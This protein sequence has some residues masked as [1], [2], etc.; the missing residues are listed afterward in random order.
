MP[1]VHCIHVWNGA[2][3][4]ILAYW[5]TFVMVRWTDTDMV[6]SVLQ[7]SIREI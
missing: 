1:T 4:I 5:G 6:E 7:D 3:G 2:Q